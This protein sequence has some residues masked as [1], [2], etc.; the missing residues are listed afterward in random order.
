MSA[1]EGCCSICKKAI[2][3]GQSYT[4]DPCACLCYCK[5]CAMKISTGGKC[6]VCKALFVGMKNRDREWA[7]SVM[8][9]AES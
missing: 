3:P 6:R 4:S 9:V 1:A 7:S 8:D 2:A 5:A